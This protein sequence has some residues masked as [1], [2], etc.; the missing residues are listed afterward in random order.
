MVSPP[1]SLPLSHSLPDLMQTNEFKGLSSKTAAPKSHCVVVVTG[2]NDILYKASHRV[3]GKR[4]SDNQAEDNN[5]KSTTP[6][7]RLTKNEDAVKS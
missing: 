3:E 5:P 1:L 6:Q 2:I 7:P 4:F